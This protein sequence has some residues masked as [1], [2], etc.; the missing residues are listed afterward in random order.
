MSDEDLASNRN[1]QCFVMGSVLLQAATDFPLRYRMGI[2]A[3]L[4]FIK[5]QNDFQTSIT[6]SDRNVVPG[7]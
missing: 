1:D 6:T 2:S 4:E 7:R 5:A 3:A